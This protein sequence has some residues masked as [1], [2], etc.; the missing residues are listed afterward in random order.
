M[1]ADVVAIIGEFLSLL[2]LKRFAYFCN[3]SEDYRVGLRHII[4][5]GSRVSNLH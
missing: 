2:G 5:L 1:L 4:V 3:I